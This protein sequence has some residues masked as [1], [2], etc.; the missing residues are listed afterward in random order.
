MLRDNFF[1][2]LK[3]A[4]E[5]DVVT[6]TLSIE[7]DHDILKGHFPGQP[8]VPGVCVMQ[9]VKELLEDSL[10]KSLRLKVADNMKFMAVI[11]PNQVSD[12][13]ANIVYHVNGRT[14]AINASLFSG[15]TTF[16][17]LKATLETA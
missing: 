4:H 16:F 11:D 13:E 2:V 14:I 8:V 6:A 12:I 15:A 1:K 3:Q 5:T 17:K 10:G 9:M 7:K